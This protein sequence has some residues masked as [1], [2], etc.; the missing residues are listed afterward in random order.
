MKLKAPGLPLPLTASLQADLHCTVQNEM[1]VNT[2]SE[3]TPASPC[4]GLALTG[5]AG[6]DCPRS[7]ALL[8]PPMGHLPHDRDPHG[9]DTEHGPSE[10]GMS[11]FYLFL[12]PLIFLPSEQIPPWPS[13]I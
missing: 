11:G 9:V 8:P 10:S 2:Y 1:Y 13:R 7:N 3:P 5:G 4:G 6:W 12:S